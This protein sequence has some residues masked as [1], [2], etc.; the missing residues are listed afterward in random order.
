MRLVREAFANRVARFASHIR[1]PSH[2][3]PEPSF[4]L[5]G[6][7]TCGELISGLSI[8]SP[9]EELSMSTVRSWAALSAGNRFEPY[10]FNP[11]PLGVYDVDIAVEYCGICH[12]DLSI[13]END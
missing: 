6:T 11:G 8:T 1:S 9:A 5:T 2:V 12:S 13:L 10:Q 4:R 3:G 7:G